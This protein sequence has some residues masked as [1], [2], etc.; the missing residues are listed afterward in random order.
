MRGALNNNTPHIGGKS[1]RVK[2]SSG[3]WSRGFNAA[4]PLGDGRTKEESRERSVSETETDL[5][6]AEKPPACLELLMDRWS[7]HM[8][9]G[10]WVEAKELPTAGVLDAY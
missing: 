3:V 4:G 9:A 8:H 6:L 10:S 7:M 1:S 2:A 5:S